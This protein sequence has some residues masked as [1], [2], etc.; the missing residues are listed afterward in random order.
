MYFYKYV[1]LVLYIL[2]NHYFKNIF[3]LVHYCDKNNE[4]YLYDDQIVFI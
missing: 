1:F 3:I 4:F 2:N